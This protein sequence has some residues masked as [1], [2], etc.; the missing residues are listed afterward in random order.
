MTAH[1]PTALQPLTPR[2]R[3]GQFI[4]MTLAILLTPVM[5]TGLQPAQAQDKPPLKILVGFPPGGSVD[6]LA[7]TVSEAMKDDFS[8]VVVDNKAGAAGRIA[9]SQLK[10]SKPDGQTVIVLPMAPMVIFPHSYK[11]LDY[12]SFK[13]FTPISQLAIAN[14]GVVA[15]PSS[16]AS[17]IRDMLA[18]V[19]ADPS[20]GNYGTPGSGSAPHFMGVLI[21]QS[22]GTPLNHV[23]FQ[24]G[25]PANTALLGG[26]IQ[27]K[28]DVVSETLQLHRDGKVKIIGVAGPRRD[29]LVPE[30]PTLKEQ[31]INIETTVWFAMYGP[32]SM[33]A[34]VLSRIEK[35]V[36]SAIKKPDV[37][38]RLAKLGFEPTGTSA[39]E[40]A[41]IHKADHARWERPIKATGIALD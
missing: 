24:G 29:P 10:A 8:S 37:R 25:A 19:K 39:N 41:A 4:A 27:Y 16:G 11:K 1:F 23:P 17:S 36:T 21:E 26:H 40:M 2:R 38:E 3:F 6:A 7:R 12:D 5:L 18:K 33:P 14:F 31:G 13:D 9:L 35:A 20:Q 34:D 30:V 28:L 15:G 22:T 32:A